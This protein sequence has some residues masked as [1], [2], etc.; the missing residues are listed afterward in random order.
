MRPA[1]LLL[2]ACHHE[3]DVT[4]TVNDT[5]GDTDSGV[6]CAPKPEVCDGLD[7]DCDG[8]ADNG[9]PSDGAGCQEPAPPEFPEL[10]GTA[11]ITIRTA[12]STFAG[13]DDPVQ[14]CFDGGSCVGA[15]VTDWNDREPGNFDVL[16]ASVDFARAEVTGFTVRTT[17][18][19]DQWRPAAFEVSFDGEPVYCRDALDVAIG[20]AS[21]EVMAWTDAFELHCDT[22]WD[23]F[24]THGPLLGAVDANGA[25]IWFRTDATRRAALRVADTPSGL[26]D[27]A[28]VAVRYPAAARDFTEVVHV[29]GLAPERTYWYDL[30]IDG[31]RS[32][33]WSF[34]T[35][36]ADGAPGLLR[37]AFGSCSKTDDQPVFGPIA[38]WD[39][40]L[41]LFVG[42]NHYGNTA[43]LG[44][45][46][47]QYRWAHSRPLRR[48]LLPETSILATWDDH[49][50]V[51]NNTDGSAAG[52]NNAVQAFTE[53]WANER[54]GTAD[55]MGVFS[56]H[57][58]GDVEFFL[59]DDRYWRGLQDSILGDAQEA[60]LFEQLDASDAVFKLV[61]S[62]SQ[63]TM[64][65]SSDSWAEFPE[66]QLRFREH[67]ADQAIAGVVL[68]SGDVHRSEFRI[69][70]G[71]PGGYGLPELTS[72]SLAYDPP[73]P[74]P[75]ADADLRDCFASTH[76][77]VGVTLDTAEADP[78]LFAEI[79]D[80]NG[81]QKAT[82]ELHLSDLGG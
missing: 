56:T 36:R 27:A 72:S 12:D 70:P 32:G 55:T 79:I 30:E 41:F 21:G 18:G 7:Q 3:I 37:F 19:G 66:A 40:D 44:A 15:D 81:A 76:Y 62:G 68:L 1:L 22:A 63:W 71:A 60:W 48:D 34:L 23:G 39:P 65:G 33:P 20:D 35:S 13:T 80:E 29:V 38:A 75:L 16:H 11:Q 61:V 69:V 64:D 5:V 74:C 51:G 47:Q 8:V 17:D 49:D 24:L 4:D 78:R 54:Y 14:I 73:S 50:Y 77:F 9:V 42:D 43:D 53:Y 52:K 82:W 26:D 45:L 59:L 25:R 31:V 2:A 67:L 57:R 46:R 28:P 6:V 58:V 10:V